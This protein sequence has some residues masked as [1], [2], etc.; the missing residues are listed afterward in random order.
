LRKKNK[1]KI[2]KKIELSTQRK[3]GPRENKPSE[4]DRQKLRKGKAQKPTG[5]SGSGR[6]KQKKPITRSRKKLRDPTA[7]WKSKPYQKRGLDGQY[8]KNTQ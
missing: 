8:P 4:N 7:P 6:E 1:E 2:R 3:G 5:Q